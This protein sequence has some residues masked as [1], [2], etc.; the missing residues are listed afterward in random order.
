M[1]EPREF[2][3]KV[4]LRPSGFADFIGQMDVLGG[5][6]IA[7]DSAKIR[8]KCLDHVLFYGPPGLGKTTL[9]SIIAREMGVGFKITSGP[10]LVK[11]G[12][13][14]SMLS[15]LRA[16]DVIFIDEIHRMNRG[17]E[18][19]LYS[20][21][22]DRC[23]DILVGEGRTARSLR[24]DLPP[25]TLVGATTRVGMLSAPLRDRF[26][27]VL[28]LTFYSID[29][30]LQVIRRGA[31]V[32][33]ISL[34][35]QGMY[36]IAKRSRGT[37]RIG[38]HLLR[39]IRDFAV[40]QSVVQIDVQLVRDAFT[41]LGVDQIGLNA[42]DRRYLEFLFQAGG[43]V[44]LDTIA[45]ALFEDTGNI[46]LVIEPYLMKIN[47]VYRTPKGREISEQAKAY[48]CNGGIHE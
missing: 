4:K 30:M 29:E 33:G 13:L 39:R 24:I 46:E 44:G 38:L 3:I 45:A 12:D 21:M 23:I 41:N 2:D 11:A 47:F 7:I 25:F 8:G 19:I 22:E 36:E 15:C 16:D 43:P 20:A 28:N 9:A 26:G 14:A 42:L 32:I 5:L 40:V 48:L 37:P 34:D 35:E 18:E 17:V 31:V 1:N 6:K 10:L 27:L